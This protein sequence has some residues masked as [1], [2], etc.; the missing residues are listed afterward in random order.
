MHIFQDGNIEI[1]LLNGFLSWVVTVKYLVLL[2]PPP[3]VS[4][5]VALRNLGAD[6]SSILHIIRGKGGKQWKHQR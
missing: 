6:L 5:L 3:F 1:I 2:C 4:L